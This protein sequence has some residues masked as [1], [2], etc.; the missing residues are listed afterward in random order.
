[1]WQ[2]LDRTD[3]NNSVV[4]SLRNVLTCSTQLRCA[5]TV[6][7]RIFRLDARKRDSSIRVGTWEI[8]VDGLSVYRCSL[9]D[10]S[11]VRNDGKPAFLQPRMPPRSLRASDKNQGQS[12]FDNEGIFTFPFFFDKSSP[13]VESV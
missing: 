4:K 13:I 12:A 11:N 1:M 5:K 7:P 2:I 10:A 3:V 8:E 9:W 6:F